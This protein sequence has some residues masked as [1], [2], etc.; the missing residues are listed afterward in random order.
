MLTAR[1]TA[2]H[3]RIE[4]MVF[5]DPA[6]GRFGNV[7]HAKADGAEFEIQQQLS[8]SLRLDANLSYVDARDIRDVPRPADQAITEVPHWMGNLGLLWNPARDLTLGLHWNHIGARSG[9]TPNSGKYDLVD[10]GATRRALFGG[11]VDLELGV[12]N[13]FNRRVIELAPGPFGDT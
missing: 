2:F 5:V 9:A 7:A 3:M 13:L 1:A 12:S 8:G 11:T 10:V 6:H 4:N